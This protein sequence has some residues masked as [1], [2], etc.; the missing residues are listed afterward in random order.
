MLAVVTLTRSAL[1]GMVRARSRMD[2][3][4]LVGGRL[5]GRTEPHRLRGDEGVRH[6][7][8]RRAARGAPRHGRLGDR[9]VPGAHAHRVPVGE[10]LARTVAGLPGVSRGCPPPR[11]RRSASPTL[12]SDSAVSSPRLREQG[13]RHDGG[14]VAP[15]ARA[16]HRGIVQS[17]LSHPHPPSACFV[18]SV[19][20]LHNRCWAHPAAH[21]AAIA[22]TVF[23][24]RELAELGD[25]MAGLDL[26]HRARLRAHDE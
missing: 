20:S 24:R 1:D 21:C 7:L 3:Q 17:S 19:A 16:P 18:G 5:P 22:V 15:R 9:V 11:S 13:V 12:Q 26:A 2:L 25:A 6:E 14:R 8:H 10:Q 4:R 23:D